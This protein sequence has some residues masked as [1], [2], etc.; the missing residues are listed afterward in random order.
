MGEIPERSIFRQP[1]LRQA[2][3]PYLEITQ[4]VRT[5]DLSKFQESLAKNNKQFK[6]DK[7]YTLILRQANLTQ[8]APQCNQSGCSSN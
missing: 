1:I 8:I 7:N 4:A 6:L 5:G 3:L 2:L